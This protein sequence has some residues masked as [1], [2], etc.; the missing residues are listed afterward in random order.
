M[1][2]LTYFLIHFFSLKFISVKVFPCFL[3]GKNTLNGS[4]VL[5]N[6]LHSAS[7]HADQPVPTT[8]PVDYCFYLPYH[9]FVSIA[10]CVPKES[11][12]CH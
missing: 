7:L 2:N 1:F 12:V 4:A 6:H 5:Y 8:E 10:L 9:L 3:S 11:D